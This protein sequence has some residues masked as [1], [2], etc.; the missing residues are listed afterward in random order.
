MHFPEKTGRKIF[1]N[2]KNV[3]NLPFSEKIRA[4]L[5]AYSHFSIK[6]Y[7]HYQ[8]LYLWKTVFF[9]CHSFDIIRL[10]TLWYTSFRLFDSLLRAAL[11]EFCR[12]KEFVKLTNKSI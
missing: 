3:E 10:F 4:E 5:R 11:L 8:H 9:R 7:P 6:G 2:R 12:E 1:Y